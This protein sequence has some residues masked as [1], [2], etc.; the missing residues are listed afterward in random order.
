MT[1]E[2]DCCGEKKEKEPYLQIV[3]N[4]DDCE[5]KDEINFCSWSCLVSYVSGAFPEYVEVVRNVE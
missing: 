2:C 5:D 1:Y 3:G 4:T